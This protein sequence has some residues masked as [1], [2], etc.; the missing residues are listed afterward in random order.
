MPIHEEDCIQD[1]EVKDARERLSAI[2][3]AVVSHQGEFLRFREDVGRRVD[4]AKT[5]AVSAEFEARS[6]AVAAAS[7]EA[8]VGALTTEV[9]GLSDRVRGLS[10]RV[11]LIVGLLTGLGVLGNAGLNAFGGDS[12]K[13]AEDVAP[14]AMIDDDDEMNGFA[15]HDLVDDDGT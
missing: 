7:S 2:E 9:T 15:D 4:G 14:G 6:A 10:V 11:A 13:D 5:A 1:N 8:K 12:E 3:S